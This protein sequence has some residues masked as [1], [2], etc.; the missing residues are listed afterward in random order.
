MKVTDLYLR[1]ATPTEAR[2]VLCG[3]FVADPVKSRE[4][5]VSIALD[6]KQKAYEEFVVKKP[7]VIKDA[8]AVKGEIGIEVIVVDQKAPL[9]EADLDIDLTTVELKEGWAPEVEPPDGQVL[10]LLFDWI[11]VG[12]VYDVD[13]EGEDAIAAPRTG[14][15]VIARWRGEGDVPDAV[16]AYQTTPWNQVIG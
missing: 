14:H 12:T 9:T 8:E 2:A 3:L 11:S 7:P 10:G 4:I 5:A 16:L 15:H 6:R 1:F 13:G